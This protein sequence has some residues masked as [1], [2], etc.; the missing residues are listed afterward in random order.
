MVWLANVCY[1]KTATFIPF[2]PLS[3]PPF[4]PKGAE[5]MELGGALVGEFLEF[6]ELWMVCHVYLD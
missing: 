1:R 6:Q 4:V 3:K 2:Q 5:E